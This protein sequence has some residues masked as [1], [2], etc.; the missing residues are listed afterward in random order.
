MKQTGKSRVEKKAAKKS[1][2][3]GNTRRNVAQEESD[4]SSDIDA[5]TK[6]YC[7][8]RQPYVEG[9]VMVQCDR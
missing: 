2:K 7:V 3:K 6:V 8:C 1:T 5:E 4:A 9:V